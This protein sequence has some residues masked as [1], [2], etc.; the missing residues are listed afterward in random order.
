M[1]K[2]KAILVRRFNIPFT[3]TDRSCRKKINTDI[4][5]KQHIRQDRL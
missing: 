4:R 3:S 2:L 1:E 5:L